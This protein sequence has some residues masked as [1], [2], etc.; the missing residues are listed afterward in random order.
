MWNLCALVRNLRVLT[1]RLRGLIDPI[2]LWVMW[3]VFIPYPFVPNGHLLYSFIPNEQK[4]SL[5]PKL[6]A[7][8][9]LA[10]IFVIP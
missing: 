3:V 5:F 7:P 10:Q 2:I 1:R 9:S 8:N 4:L 6:G